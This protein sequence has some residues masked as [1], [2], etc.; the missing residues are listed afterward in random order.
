MIVLEEFREY[1]RLDLETLGSELIML[2]NSPWT[3]LP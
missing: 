3:L 1:T 2:K